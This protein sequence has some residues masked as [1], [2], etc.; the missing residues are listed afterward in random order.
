MGNKKKVEPSYTLEQI[1]KCTPYTSPYTNAPTCGLNENDFMENLFVEPAL[2]KRLDELQSQLNNTEINETERNIILKEIEKLQEDIKKKENFER[3]LLECNDPHVRYIC[4]FSGSG[5]STYLGKI[6]L[7]L[8]K[9][10]HITHTFDVADTITTIATLFGTDYVNPQPQETLS[11]FLLKILIDISVLISKKNQEPYIKYRARLNS[12]VD[13]YNRYIKSHYREYSNYFN[14]IESHIENIEDDYNDLMIGLHNAISSKLKSFTKNSNKDAIINLI[15]YYLGLFVMI[16]FSEIKEGKKCFI[17]MDSIEHFI[18]NDEVYDRDIVIITDLFEDLLTQLNHQYSNWIRPN[19]FAE[20][21]VFII[22][23]RDT[24][25]KTLPTKNGEDHDKKEIN[26]SDWFVPY[27]IVEK[28]LNYFFRNG[29][30]QPNIAKAIKNILCDDLHNNGALNNKISM[31]YNQNK[32]RLSEYL[33]KAITE[34]DADQYLKIYENAQSYRMLLAKTTDYNLKR[35]YSYLANVYTHA[36]REFVVNILFMY[37][38]KKDYFN[39]IFTRGARLHIGKSYARRILNFIATKRPNEG[40]YEKDN[41]IGFLELIEG[42]F[43]KRGSVLEKDILNT[44]ADVLF[45]LSNFSKNETHWCQNVVIKFNNTKYSKEELR[46]LVNNFYDNKTDNEVDYGIKITPAG[47]FFLKKMADYEYF[48]CRYISGGKSLFDLSYL[49]KDGEKFNCINVIQQIKTQTFECI[50]HII[51]D[52][53]RF[54]SWGVLDYSFMYSE[55]DALTKRGYLYVNDNGREITHAERI[56]DN[57][58]G[59]LDHYRNYLID[60]CLK[61]GRLS[62]SDIA[63]VS[64]EIIAVIE[65]YVYKLKELTEIKSVNCGLTSYYIGNR[66]TQEEGKAYYSGYLENIE[67]ARRDPLLIYAINK[68]KSGDII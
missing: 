62:K 7:E 68:Y 61:T 29:N 42:T 55:E 22:S 44:I 15:K 57:H 25:V 50:D 60:I 53:K 30:S 67:N 1:L 3:E 9:K 35:K 16:K 4:G 49:A 24:T 12:Y 43:Q 56:I 13:F 28:R 47:K 32:R 31:M 66:R 51:D 34:K 65:S 36:A 2:N 8:R 41:Y 20:K 11:K 37:I 6:L 63:S 38:N 59:Y 45:Y 19:F 10:G 5:K 27:D 17:A 21:F 18:G 14:L 26:I 23:L 54:F 39:K 40:L 52:D 46:K 58:I 48:I 64:K 33:C